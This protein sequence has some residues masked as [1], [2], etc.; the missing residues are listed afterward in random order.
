MYVLYQPFDIVVDDSSKQI[1]QSF[2]DVEQQK[3]VFLV[4]QVIFLLLETKAK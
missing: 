4:G 2:T 1:I 3:S